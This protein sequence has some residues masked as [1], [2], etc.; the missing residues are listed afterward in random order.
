MQ[1]H[2]PR[3]GRGEHV[4]EGAQAAAVEA[5]ASLPDRMRRV[6]S[7]PD[8]EPPL[9][10]RAALEVHRLAREP[11]VNLDEIV[12][13][14]EQDALLASQTLRRSRSVAFSTRV[15]P[16]S[17]DE[18]VR[19]IGLD[20]VRDIVWE[21]AMHMRVFRCKPYAP[22]MEALRRHSVAVATCTKALALRTSVAAE[23]AFL[24]GLLHDVGLAAMLLILAEERTPPPL[25]E[26][27][28]DLVAL[29]EEAAETVGR[30]WGLPPE[31]TLI[32]AH[33]H[34]P[35]IGGYDHPV[36]AALCVGHEM[37]Q[38]LGHGL[39]WGGLGRDV[40]HPN[41]LRRALDALDLTLLQV[42]AAAAETA[43]RLE[44]LS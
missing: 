22:A 27:A 9:L 12:T 32:V 1:R 10:P 19:R 14:V 21:T 25:E 43:A 13:L 39:Q 3:Y 17:L 37:A 20:N 36:V 41:Q 31:L 30:A 24:A 11:D 16:Q 42:E 2:D 28:D 8:Y 18:A 34:H 7:A 23:Y 6:L 5:V 26:V 35:T 29:H 33:H 15:P 4:I 44:A 40:T 38:Q